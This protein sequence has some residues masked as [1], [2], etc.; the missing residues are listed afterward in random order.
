MEQDVRQWLQETFNSGSAE[1]SDGDVDALLREI[2][3]SDDDLVMTI[4]FVESHLSKRALP[5]LFDILIDERRSTETRAASARAIATIADV[6]SKAFLSSALEADRQRAQM[7]A[8][9]HEHQA[10]VQTAP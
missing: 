1:L 9:A 8:E 7:W 4:Q 10:P 6:Q 3:L 5:A 2:S